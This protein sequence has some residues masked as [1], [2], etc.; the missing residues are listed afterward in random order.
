MYIYTYIGIVYRNY[1][2]FEKC[3]DLLPEATVLALG[4]PLYI[5]TAPAIYKNPFFYLYF[6]WFL[7]SFFLHM[8]VRY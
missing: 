8:S 5:K 4:R 3:K 1:D 2:M 6:L 7:V